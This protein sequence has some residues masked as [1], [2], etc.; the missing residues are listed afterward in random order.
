M[1]N[2]DFVTQYLSKF[3]LS[4]G[5]NYSTVLGW[6]VHMVKCEVINKKIWDLI[7]A[8]VHHPYVWYSLSIVYLKYNFGLVENMSREMRSFPKSVV[9]IL[10]RKPIVVNCGII[11]FLERTH[12]FL[13]PLRCVE[14]Y[15]SIIFSS[16]SVLNTI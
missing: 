15:M 4:T 9:F 11:Q 5:R 13:T 10:A 1:K 12:M 14:H 3:D 8:F 16:S 2:F 6:C 7:L